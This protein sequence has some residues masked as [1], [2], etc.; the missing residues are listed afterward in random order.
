MTHLR[1]DLEAALGGRFAIERELGADGPT[2]RLLAE[3]TAL[4]RRVAVTILPLELAT[5]LDGE[6]FGRQ[7]ELATSLRHPHIVPVLAAGQAGG[8]LY[9]VTPFVEGETL[10]TRLAR[11]GRLPVLDATRILRQVAEALAYAHRR[12]VV[13]R[14]FRPEHVLLADNRAFV[15]GLGVA[16]AVSLALHDGAGEVGVALGTAAYLAPEQAVADPGVDH[17]ADIYAVGVVAYEMLGGRTPFTGP[18]AQVA[19]AQLR[20]APEPL[21]LV[22]P[23]LPPALTAAVMRCLE[24]EPD[25]RWPSAGRLRLEIEALPTAGPL[26]V[27]PPP[28]RRWRRLAAVLAVL[29]VAVLAVLTTRRRFAAGAG[30]PSLVAVLPFSVRGPADVAYLGEGMVR[31]LAT[32]LDGAGDLRVADPRAALGMARQVGPLATDTARGA[33][34]A[35]R[36]G[37]GRF[38]LGD[39]VAEGRRLRIRASLYEPERGPAPEATASVEG[40]VAQLLSLVDQLAGRLLASAGG[41]PA[42]RTTR[43]AG[44]TT[45]SLP[46][47]KAYLDGEAAL[48]AGWAD[49]AIGAF[50]RAVAADTGFALAYDALSVAAG[51]ATRARLAARAA[52][53]AMLRGA[54]LPDRDRGLLEAL[55]VARRGDGRGAETMYRSIL[56]AHPDDVEAWIQLG[57]VLFHLGPAGGRPPAA[58]A[59]AWERVLSFDPTCASAVLHLARLAALQRPPEVVD[60]LIGPA[61]AANPHGSRSPELRA[62][63]AW[64]LADSAQEQRV[65]SELRDAG[66]AEVALAAWDVAAYARDAAGAEQ[67]ARLLTAPPRPRLTR[68][69]GHVML[70]YLELTRGRLA[71]ARTEIARAGADDSVVALEFGTLLELS[72]FHQAPSMTLERERWAL[73]HLETGRL[74]AA[75]SPSVLFAAH[76]GLQEL[77]RAYLVGMV[78]ARLGNPDAAAEW[79]ARLD[80]APAPEA[81]PA[82]PRDLSLE[83]RAEIALRSG[84]AAQ[85]LDLLAQRRNRAGY[86]YVRASPLVS[87]SRAR[88]LEATLAAAAH[89]VPRAESLLATFGAASSYDLV[90]AAPAHFRRAVLEEAAGDP[91]SAAAD[92]RRFLELWQGADPVFA[93]QLDSARAGLARLGGSGRGDTGRAARRRAARP[94]SR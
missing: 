51:R 69:V 63:R 8:M 43:L 3:D 14:D 28:P 75:G 11:D 86:A 53:D 24:K 93:P 15:T 16:Q 21:G 41:V 23:D 59:A 6:R 89:D 56:A 78:R 84:N 85:A 58:S 31:L 5:V 38:V 50:E 73:E 70:G 12:Q 83:I 65:L 44:V 80:S 34:V 33:R 25:A 19:A 52:R 7:I 71:G 17:R 77:V 13:H 74:P 72:P 35:G 40:D 64:V 9:F 61:L 22:R 55:R 26:A 92:Y 62:L 91:R 81:A 39:V 36:L 2:R 68:A 37:A 29:A 49:S 76:D 60:S 48:R 67:V 32:S 27:L 94:D 47:L 87:E 46:A 30:S 42:P 57:E 45:S 54:R 66:D 18:P 1:G 20:N 79:A 88:Y 10:R 82:L 4:G 90:Y